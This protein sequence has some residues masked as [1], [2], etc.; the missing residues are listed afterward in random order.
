MNVSA[1]Q[2]A[3]ARINIYPARD[4]KAQETS[5]RS[6]LEQVQQSL[7]SVG[8]F[9]YITSDGTGISFL[10]NYANLG[11]GYGSGSSTYSS[12]SSVYLSPSGVGAVGSSRTTI[13]PQSGN[14]LAVGQSVTVAG[15][16]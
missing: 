7:Q 9:S 2:T 14:S 16:N 8:I 15:G 4:Y 3:S 10:S 13:S 11:S 6:I 1:T 12:P 5:R